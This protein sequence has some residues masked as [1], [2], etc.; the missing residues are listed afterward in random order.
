MKH[1][2]FPNRVLTLF[3]LPLVACGPTKT[4][5]ELNPGVQFMDQKQ[6]TEFLSDTKL[7]TDNVVSVMY[8]A[9]GKADLHVKKKDEDISVNWEVLEDGMVVF[10]T[11]NRTLK[12]YI[13]TDETTSY[14]ST[15][16]VVH[17]KVIK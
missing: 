2:L 12:F 5:Q 16:Q 9:S 6:V 1:H 14:R 4:T 10:R 8:N 11:N 15:G 3:A 13:V 7:E 17:F